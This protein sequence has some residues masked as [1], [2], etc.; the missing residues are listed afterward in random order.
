MICLLCEEIWSEIRL[1][2]EKIRKNEEA[3]FRNEQREWD[4]ISRELTTW[5][6]LTLNDEAKSRFSMIDDKMLLDVWWFDTIL[7]RNVFWRKFKS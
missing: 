6:Y 4:S 1:F 5:S 2:D 3:N 7:S